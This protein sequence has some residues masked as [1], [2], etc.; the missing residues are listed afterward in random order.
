MSKVNELDKEE[1]RSEK[2][3]KNATDMFFSHTGFY[4]HASLVLA[5]F[6]NIRSG[7]LFDLLKIWPISNI[8]KKIIVCLPFSVCLI[9]YFILIIIIIIIIEANHRWHLF[10]TRFPYNYDHDNDLVSVELCH[11]Q[12]DN[13]SLSAGHQTTRRRHLLARSLVCNERWRRSPLSPPRSQPATPRIYCN[14]DIVVSN[15]QP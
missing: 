15:F 4:R 12:N 14:M 9:K 7:Y 2:K 10:V 5:F 11:F 13:W 3:I 1:H 8:K 6:F